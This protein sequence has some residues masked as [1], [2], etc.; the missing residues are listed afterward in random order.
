MPYK[1][2]LAPPPF[3][4]RSSV[5]W[6]PHFVEAVK[7]G[8]PAGH[9]ELVK[10]NFHFGR[11]QF[12]FEHERHN[13][14][15]QQPQFVQ[16][17]SLDIALAMFEEITGLVVPEFLRVSDG[18]AGYEVYRDGAFQPVEGPN[19]ASIVVG[20]LYQIP[21]GLSRLSDMAGEYAGVVGPTGETVL[22]RVSSGKRDQYVFS[23]LSPEQQERVVRTNLGLPLVPESRFRDRSVAVALPI[24]DAAPAVVRPRMR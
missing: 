9:T 19:P 1:L 3:L 8:L 6:N 11:N 14:I 15:V 12:V 17:T 13:P 10:V 21:K 23:E 24:E 4:L 20:A 5:W 16:H 7:Q 22:E 18:K 2:S